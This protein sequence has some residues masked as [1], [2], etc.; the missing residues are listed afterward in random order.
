MR[1]PCAERVTAVHRSFLAAQWPE[2]HLP[3]TTWGQRREK[4]KGNP[5]P[6]PNPRRRF[7][8]N[9]LVQIGVRGI[10]TCNSDR[11]TTKLTGQRRE[12]R[13]EYRR[14]RRQVRPHPSRTSG[15]GAGGR[16]PLLSA[17]GAVC[18]GKCSSTQT[19]TA[20]HRVHPSLCHGGA[21][22]AERKGI[23]AVAAGG[24]RVYATTRRDGRPF[25]R[26]RAGSRPSSGAKLRSRELFD[27]YGSTTETNPQKIGPAFFP[28]RN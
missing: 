2:V 5:C 16:Q 12:Y 24:A 19:E 22:N 3:G 9:S 23:R 1:R 27:R 15:T 6:Q 11:Q 28:S 18:A 21:R 4:E 14:F 25:D 8:Q 7:P 10:K 26:L 17:A 13:Y 20:A